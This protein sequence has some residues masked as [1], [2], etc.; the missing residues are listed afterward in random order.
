MV[1]MKKEGHRV[2]VYLDQEL[3]EKLEEAA[4][5]ERKSVS[6]FVRDLV[7]EKIHP[8]RRDK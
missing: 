8:K 2:S 1:T 6:H 3:R 7:F 4:K 5:Q